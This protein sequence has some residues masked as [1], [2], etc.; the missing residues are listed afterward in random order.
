MQAA[1]IEPARVA[2]PNLKVGASTSSAK[3][4]SWARSDLNRDRSGYEPLALP[5]SYR[6]LRS[7][8]G[9]APVS[10]ARQAGRDSWSRHAPSGTRSVGGGGI[11]PPSSVCRT[12]AATTRPTSVK[13]KR[14]ESHLRF[15][16]VELACFCCTTLALSGRLDSNQP[17]YGPQPYA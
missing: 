16:R 5:L 2:P 12:E 3:P 9:A 14:E 17:R 11:E 7:I 13:C 6:P 1:G 15:Q 8:T 10:P 4:A